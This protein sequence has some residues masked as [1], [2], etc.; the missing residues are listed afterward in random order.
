MN[1]GKHNQGL[2]HYPVLFSLRI[3]NGSCNTFDDISNIMSVSNKTKDVIL[4]I[5]NMIARINE[6]KRLKKNVVL[7]VNSIENRKFNINQK[8]NND[9]CRCECKNS[10][11]HNVC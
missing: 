9:K 1:L 4:N 2:H 3:C 6:P 5:F 10:I 11:K 7:V 8:W